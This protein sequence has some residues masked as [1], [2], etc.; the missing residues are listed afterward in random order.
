MPS[1]GSL[2][3]SY[4]GYVGQTIEVAGRSELTLALKTDTNILNEVVVTAQGIRKSSREI[5][6]AL[7]KVTTDDVTVGRSP[8]LAQALSGKVTGLAVYNINNGVD[9]SVKIVLRGFRSLTGNNEALVVVD[10]MQTTA[11]ILALINPNDIDNVSI[12]KGGQAAT[13]Y[14]SA[15]INGAMVITTKKGSKGKPRVSYSNSTNFDQISFLPDIQNK[16]GN[17]SQYYPESFGSANYSSDYMV[18]MKANWRPYENQQYGD[19]F[20]GQP[21][22][23]G[24]VVESGN[25][26]I[27]PYAAID[28][29]RRKNI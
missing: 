9:P 24:R 5:G 25:K 3:F 26:M 22:L 28:N 19:P 29:V 6:Y 14:G 16:Y 21:R 1:N 20:D 4:I 15:G 27:I 10:G 13:L 23:V 17:G 2:S 11:T 18:R 12:L 8:Q 7:S